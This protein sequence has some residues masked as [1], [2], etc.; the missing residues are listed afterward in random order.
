MKSTW[1]L[2]ENSTGEL[3]VVVEGETWKKAQ[4]KAFD[5]LSKEVEVDG[6]RKGTAPK[7]VIEKQ[8]KKESILM[9]AMEEMA[10]AALVAGVEEHKLELV[11]RPTLNLNSLDEDKVEYKFNVT[12]KPEVKLGKYKGLDIKPEEVKVSSQ[13]VNEVLDQLQT[14]FAELIIKE[15]PIAEGDTAVID[16]EGFVDDVAFEGGKGESYPLEIGSQTFIPGFEEQLVGV[17]PMAEVDVVVTF[18]EAYQADEL[19]GKEAVFKVKVNEVKERQLPELNDDFAKEVNQEGVETLAELKAAVKKDLLVEKE[20]KTKEEANNKLLTTIIDDCEVTIPEVMVEEEVL[21]LLEDFKNR[22]AQQGFPYE[23]FLEMTGQ[24]EEDLKAQ[25]GQDAEMK[26]K[27]RLVLDAIAKA[28]NISVTAEEIE[29]EYLAAAEM[30]NIEV[31]KFKEM[32][33]A[34]TIEYDLVLRKA[35]DFIQQSN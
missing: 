12:V 13:E 11:T 33:P 9:E 32:I 2:L 19:A 30:Y 10:N 16:F 4:D 28:E 14:Q 26:V 18:P 6:F 1:K 8:L 15:G 7:S 31:D 20:K 25:M 23:Q 22:L 27:L 34:D 29:D 5:K 24:K 35:F 17:S 21:N 3:C